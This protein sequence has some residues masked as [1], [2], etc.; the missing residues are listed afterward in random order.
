[1]YSFVV[2]KTEAAYLLSILEKALYTDGTLQ[3]RSNELI[4]RSGTR[5]SVA[6]HF[7][8]FHLLL[9]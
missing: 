9:L 6:V 7:S 3:N 1:M 5:K 2:D 8:P 4:S